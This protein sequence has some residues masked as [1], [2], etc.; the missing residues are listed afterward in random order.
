MVYFRAEEIY[1]H[2]PLFPDSYR[3]YTVQIT[4]FRNQVI[5]KGAEI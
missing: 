3:G 1:I 4:Q 5:E 2:K